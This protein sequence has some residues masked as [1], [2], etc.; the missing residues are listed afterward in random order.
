MAALTRRRRPEL[1]AHVE[2]GHADRCRLERES[3]GGLAG[4]QPA[5]L[6]MQRLG[7]PGVVDGERGLDG[8]HLEQLLLQ[9]PGPAAV[10][11]QV[12]REDADELAGR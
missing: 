4:L 11:G 1:I 9:R 6:G 3:E 2:H 5:L 12:D 8:E 7:Q 10:R